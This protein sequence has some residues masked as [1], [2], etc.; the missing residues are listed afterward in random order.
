MRAVV[1][2]RSD[3]LRVIAV[4]AMIGAAAAYAWVVADDGADD[5]LR[6]LAG[7]GAGL[8]A[9][10]LTRLGDGIV[11][12][13]L[14]FKRRVAIA[15]AALLVVIAILPGALVLLRGVSVADNAEI[16]LAGAAAGF[17]AA[18]GVLYPLGR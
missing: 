8:L 6:F 13:R 3:P 7:A 2:T 10:V 9:G 15:N 5:L 12:A 17:F 16:L 4:L 11:A 1:T 18:V 14:P